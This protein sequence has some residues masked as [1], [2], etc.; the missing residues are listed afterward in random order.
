MIPRFPSQLLQQY[1]DANPAVGTKT[2]LIALV[3]ACAPLEKLR[4]PRRCAM[5]L[6]S[7]AETARAAG[8]GERAARLLG[9]AT[10]VRERLGTPLTASSQTDVEQAVAAAQTALGEEAWAAAFAAGRALS[11]EQTIAEAL[12]EPD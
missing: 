1:G 2:N 11:L 8:Q 10:A 4:D 3:N 6:E 5:V 9:A 7:L 12:K